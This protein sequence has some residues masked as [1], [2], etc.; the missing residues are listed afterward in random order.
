ML[1][2]PDRRAAS[3]YLWTASANIR[4]LEG[5]LPETTAASVRR[6]FALKKCRCKCKR[7]CNVAEELSEREI[8]SWNELL[9]A[10]LDRFFFLIGCYNCETR[11]LVLRKHMGNLSMRKVM[12]TKVWSVNAIGIVGMMEQIEEEV[13]FLNEEKEGVA[14][15]H[16]MGSHP[17]HQEENQS[18]WRQ[19]YGNQGRNYEHIVDLGTP[20]RDESIHLK[21]EI[22]LER[23]LERVVSTDLGVRELKHDLLT[24]T[25]IV[26]S[27]AISIRH[28]EE[29]MNQL[30]SQIELGVSVDVKGPL[31]ETVTIIPEC[32]GCC[33]DNMT[34]STKTLPTRMEDVDEENMI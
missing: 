18:S 23:V 2:E 27:H 8:S 11:S 20:E 14:K 26:K 13:Y 15:N 24:L 22:M 17:N 25:Q 30:A 3:W 10:F 6:T 1:L 33:E 7:S 16:D 32:V 29:R 9:D 5:A 19:G 4:G 34:M 31:V 12:E 21:I 28:L